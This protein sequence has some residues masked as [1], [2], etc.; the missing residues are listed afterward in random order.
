MENQILYWEIEDYTGSNFKLMEDGDKIYSQK[1]TI[2]DAEKKIGKKLK[3][4]PK[5]IDPDFIIGARV[6]QNERVLY[7]ARTGLRGNTQRC[8]LLTN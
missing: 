2:K 8:F 6:M 1:L 7:D 5:D 3:V 4:C